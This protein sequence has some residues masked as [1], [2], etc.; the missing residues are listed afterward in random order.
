[1]TSIS[2][3]YLIKYLSYERPLEMNEVDPKLAKNN[4]HITYKPS[5]L[6]TEA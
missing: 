6:F 5:H 2:V 4:A 3:S 1:M